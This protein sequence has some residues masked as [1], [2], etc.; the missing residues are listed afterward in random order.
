MKT[1]NV[2]I[3]DSDIAYTSNVCR[4]L[5][6]SREIKIIGIEY[7]GIK[8]LER[9]LSTRPDVVLMDIQLPGMDGI[10]VLKE[11][12]L[13]KDP[14]LTIISTHFYS[15]FCVV[16]AR[17]NGAGY[18]LYKPIVYHTL[19]SLISECY[20]A[21]HTDVYKRRQQTNRREIS[22]DTAYMVRSILFDLGMPARFIGH[23]YLIES[24]LLA[25]ENRMLLGNLTK[26][27]YHEMAAKLN[28]TPAGIERSLRNAISATYERGS[29]STVFDHRPSNKQFLEYLMQRLKEC[30]HT[31][32]L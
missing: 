12:R 8:G 25:A 26:G 15:D 19:P 1:L 16:S 22:I 24:V 29:L 17:Q 30:A 9:I 32:S 21:T 18:I 31:P 6:V 7:D 10:S 13:M 11:S 2:L 3:I 28:T 14:P 27:L 20:K 5:S 4:A 23:M